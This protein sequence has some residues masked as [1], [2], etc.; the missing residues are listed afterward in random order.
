MKDYRKELEDLISIVIEEGASDMHLSAG[1]YP[2]I[3]VFDTLIPLTKKDQISR[4][5]ALGFAREMIPKDQF[6]EFLST[7]EMDFSFE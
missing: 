6:E 5:D 4:E 7:K 1:R 3:R 2:I